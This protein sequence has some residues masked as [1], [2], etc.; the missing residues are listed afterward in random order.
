[1]LRHNSRIDSKE[2][3][4]LGFDR[5]WFSSQSTNNYCMLLHKRIISKIRN[6][7]CIRFKNDIEMWAVGAYSSHF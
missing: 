2:V 5:A 3:L 6:I 1:M 7:A 4:S